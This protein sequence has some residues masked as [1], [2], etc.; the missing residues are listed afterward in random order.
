MNLKYFLLIIVFSLTAFVSKAQINIGNNTSDVDYSNPKEYTIG[1]ITVTGI[2]YLD[3]NV[4]IMLSGLSVG[5]KVKV[6]GDKITNAIE[7]LWKQGLF[8]DISISATKVQGDLIFLNIDIKERPRL[9]KFFF[10]GVRKSEADNLRDKIKL[11]RGDVVTDNLI[12][13]TNNII[14]KY[15]TNKGFLDADVKITSREDPKKKNNVILHI[16][17]KKHKKIKICNIN[18]YGNK[19]LSDEKVK[20][21]FK[22]TKEKSEFNPLAHIDQVIFYSLKYALNLHFDSIFVKAYNY[23]R[24]D[25]RFRIFKTSKYIKDD[26]QKDKV[27]LIKKYNELGYRDAKI[28][29]DSIYKNDDK[30]INIDITVD[31]GKK[32]YFRNITW[33]GNTKFSD[34]ILN[35]VLKIK[36]GDVYNEEILDANLNYNPNGL[37]VSS[38]YMDNGY[39]FFSVEPVEVAVENDSID[40]EIRIHEGKQAIIN[41]VSVK[42][43]T[44]TNDH[45]VIRELRTKPGNLFSRQDIIRSTRELAQLKYFDAEKIKPDV[46]PNPAEGTVD[47]NYNVEETS[48]DQVELSGGWGYG[49]VIGTLGLSFNNFSTKNIFKKK[50]W[51][52]IPT[53]DGQKLSIRMQSYGKGYLSYRASF[54]EPWLG[55]KKPNA[56]SVSYYHSLFSNALPTSDTNRQSFRIDGLSF[57]LGKRLSWP[58]DYFFVYQGI[59]LQRYDLN[60]YSR[61]F[62]FGNG[63]GY[64]NNF[65]YSLSLSRSSID[66]PIYPRSGSEVLV[67][68]E[69]TPPY[70]LFQDKDYKNMEEQDKYKWIEYHKWKIKASWF[71]KITGDLVLFART[72]YGFLGCYN[73]DIGVTPFNRFYLGGDGLS[74]Y[75][76]MDGRELIGMRGY[77]NESLTPNYYK[78]HNTGGTIYNKNTFELRYPVSLKPNATIFVLG[79]LEAGNSW[80]KFKEFNPFDLYRSAGLGIRVYLPMFGLLGLDWGYGFDKVPGIP[81]ANRGQFHFSMNHSID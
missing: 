35:S 41:K 49:R 64:Y 51:R 36:K 7:K 26:Y 39:L 21:T 62:A 52:P 4:L 63:N 53:G 29:K 54:T 45:V 71:T 40:L 23:A 68:L 37:D 74:G 22:K 72:K 43:N 3:N 76:N 46:E 59:N 66:A 47:I 34:D 25:F 42:G 69:L 67:S 12:I 30:T 17:I 8:E 2:Q 33:V 61:I 27:K 50:A 75:N 79:F 24:Q 58:D 15:Y 80:L 13:R 70:S 16:N 14:K 56:L 65:S 1:G 55:G 60:N 81:D 9:S 6:P 32:Y 18:I 19:Y 73:K 78:T 20:K 38:L 44:K 31:E 77:S 5:E 10:S 57:S 28:V 11:V 48:S